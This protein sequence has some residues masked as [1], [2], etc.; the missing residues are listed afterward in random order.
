[1]NKQGKL[2]NG[3]VVGG[4]EWLKTF[5]PDGTERQ[6]AT[7][8]VVGGCFHRCRWKMPDDKIAICYAESTAEG[9]AQAHYPEGFEH[10]YF[11][12]DRL[13]EP[14]RIKEPIRIFLDSMADLMG[15]WVPA[16]QIDQILD[17]CRGEE[18]HTFLILTKNAPRLLP[19]LDRIPRN[20]HVGISTPPDFYMGNELSI[21]QKDRMLDVALQVLDRVARRGLIAWMSVEPLSWNVASQFLESVDSKGRAAL[22]WAV[23]GAA[24]NGREYFQPNANH[25]L[26]LLEVFDGQGVPVF[27]K[28]NLRPSL[29]KTFDRW[30][31]DYPLDRK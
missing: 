12:P 14:G 28:G 11:H 13:D 29:G 16:A 21:M 20:V 5:L 15:S 8:N 19:F 27:F 3:K 25:L 1:M 18:R 7:W 9:V 31:E 23:I 26:D 10:H 4:I 24:S 30:R 6:G 2:I 17:I 22:D